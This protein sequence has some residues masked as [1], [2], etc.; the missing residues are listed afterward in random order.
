MPLFARQ[1]SL[2][3]VRDKRGFWLFG[4]LLPI[5]RHRGGIGQAQGD[6]LS[7]VLAGQERIRPT[8]DFA[9]SLAAT[10]SQGGDPLQVRPVHDG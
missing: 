10:H 7:A 6:G 2:S 3:G 1:G 9:A 8:G 5:Q 4:Y